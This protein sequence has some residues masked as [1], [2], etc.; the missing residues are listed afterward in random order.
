MAHR[1]IADGSW[2]ATH[3]DITGR[4]CAEKE[5]ERTRKFLDTVIEN[6]PATIIVKEPRRGPIRSGQSRRRAVH[7]PV[8][9]P[10]DR[11]DRSGYSVRR[12]MPTGSSRTTSRYCSRATASW[13]T[14]IRSQTP[15]N[16]LRSVVTR[17]LVIRDEE[18][19]P[20]YLLAVIEDVTERKQAEDQIAHMAL[21]DALTD[22][23]N[24]VL[25][26][27]RLEQALTWVRRGENLAVLC[28]DLDHFKNVNDTLRPSARRRAAQG[29]GRR[30][31]AAACGRPTRWRDWAA[32]S[33]PS[34][35]PA[36]RSRP[37]R[38]RW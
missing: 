26:H 10:A 36:S 2:V 37:T 19:E 23:P 25:F 33:L 34:F 32:T 20:Q 27:R 38:W 1:P 31:C 21:H 3:E 5:L 6:V 29:R 15:G 30:V 14:S 11:Q 13:A 17:K 8:P 16:G 7:R 4:R 12:K 9:R 28:L 35:R 18:G 22:L 24:R